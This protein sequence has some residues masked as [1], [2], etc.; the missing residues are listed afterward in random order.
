MSKL[1]LHHFE[2]V[3]TIAR[4]G[5]FRAAAERLN[6]TQPAISARVR[7]IEA[8]LQTALF[9]REGRGVVL[10]ARGR[11]LVRECEPLLAQF[12]RV[13]LQ[14]RGYSSAAGVVRIGVG[15]IAAATC[16]PAFVDTINRDMPQVT[17]DIELDLT[18][19]M[20][21]NLQAGKA[22]LVF[23]AGPV[24]APGLR[25]TSIGSVGFMWVAAA[26]INENSDAL[27]AA[28][29][30]GQVPVWSIGPHSP[31]YFIMER[32]LADN[33]LTGAAIH[34]C[35]NVQTILRIVGEGGGIALLPQTM[36]RDALEAGRLREVLS[37]PDATI[38]FQSCIRASERD[39]LILDLFA[40]TE[41]L[42]ING[43]R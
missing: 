16:L 6:T 37:P 13:L 15:E 33:G 1:A 29:A 9:R 8:Q 5:S 41:D 23:L 34:R 20:M 39:P 17:L 36:V 40:R 14:I 7:E 28:V 26:G 4:L 31:I 38:E 24:A 22:D 43:Q 19:R 32:W 18:S 27:L 35:N 30:S 2:T 11:Q 25:T 3:L 10:T 12:D 42:R 21:Q